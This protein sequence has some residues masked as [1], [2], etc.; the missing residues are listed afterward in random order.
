MDRNVGRIPGGK[1]AEGV[2]VLVVEGH[3]ASCPWIVE[4]LGD[5]DTGHA[6]AREAEVC[7]PAVDRLCTGAI[8]G[9]EDRDGARRVREARHKIFHRRKLDTE[10]VVL[11]SVDLREAGESA[12]RFGLDA[13]NDVWRSE[14]V[15]QEA[16]GGTVR[17]DAT[18]AL[19]RE[20]LEA[21]KFMAD[22]WKLSGKL[23]GAV[24]SRPCCTS[25]SAQPCGARRW[26]AVCTSAINVMAGPFCDQP[27]LRQ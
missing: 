3:E 22:I 1:H 2:L 25:R 11:H 21:R 8:L 16:A 15:E 13:S 23:L 14:D 18:P 12:E 7:M 19:H 9:R 26:Q 4:G 6:G 17:L 10:H 5:P 27:G 24:I 20:V